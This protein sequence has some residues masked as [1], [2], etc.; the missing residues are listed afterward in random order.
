[1]LQV[2]ALTGDPTM[3]GE[4]VIFR[5]EEVLML[6]EH[7]KREFNVVGR[8][9]K[10]DGQITLLRNTRNHNTENNSQRSVSGQDVYQCS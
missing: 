8:N 5:D 3:T 7:A 6:A 9:S 4:A 1:M 2:N 10:T